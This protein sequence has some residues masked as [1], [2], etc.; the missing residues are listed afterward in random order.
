[1]NVPNL[2]APLLFTKT[3]VYGDHPWDFTPELIR[4]FDAEYI[5]VDELRMRLAGA[6][7]EDPT[8]F[9]CLAENPPNKR[10]L[11][12]IAGVLT[13]QCLQDGQ[14]VVVEALLNGDKRQQEHLAIAQ[15][16][17][18]LSIHLCM[19]TP[20]ELVAQRIDEAELK[21]CF[22]VPRE[23]FKIIT[24]G[25]DLLEITHNLHDQLRDERPN[26]PHLV[27]DG[28]LS[29]G[30]LITQVDEYVENIRDF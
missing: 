19:D 15:E 4:H 22:H 27:L 25:K 21:D 14:N 13:K 10:R 5:N 20:F 2:N 6:D 7:P 8:T 1:M 3:G 17:G 24:S 28:S 16:A 26:I 29:T 18:A 23:A 9:H 12:L 11:R 30:Q